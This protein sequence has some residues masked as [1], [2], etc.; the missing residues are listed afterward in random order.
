MTKVK[1]LTS[2]EILD[3]LENDPWWKEISD[4]MDR[5]YM[6]QQLDI[7]DKHKHETVEALFEYVSI[8]DADLVRAESDPVYREAK[9]IIDGLRTGE[10]FP[11][12]L[13]DLY[14][15]KIPETLNR[16]DQ[17]ARKLIPVISVKQ[18]RDKLSAMWDSD[19]KSLASIDV[20]NLPKE[21]NVQS[22]DDRFVLRSVVRLQELDDRY[23]NY[24]VPPLPSKTY[25][26]AAVSIAE[27]NNIQVGMGASNEAAERRLRQRSKYLAYRVYDPLW[28]HQLERFEPEYVTFR[29]KWINDTELIDQLY[30]L[31]KAGEDVLT[32]FISFCESDERLQRLANAISSCPVTTAYGELF[33][34]IVENYKG[35]RYRIAATGLLPLIEGIIWEFAWWWNNVNRNLFDR[36]ITHSEYNSGKAEYYLLKP[37][38][39]KVKGRPN[40]GSLLRQT[41]FGEDV[42]F[43]VVE[44]LVAELFEERNPPLHGRDPFYGTQKKA[45][46][47]IFVVE[48][49]ERQITE[50]IKKMVGKDL[51]ERIKDEKANSATAK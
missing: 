1:K 29:L 8:S 47:L 39:S 13:F 3:K 43:E 33:G 26:P 2:D 7:P 14:E 21:L 24:Y 49:L 28:H 20:S 36:P 10:T 27:N 40:I 37:N 9:R 50:A 51:L 48:T 44:Y 6:L 46:A 18:V 19:R 22:A 4:E 38:G 16:L 23:R 25:T 5:V 17:I 45:A 35:G 31:H 41:K 34:E 30:K 15:S 12:R 32:V 42:Y 11:E